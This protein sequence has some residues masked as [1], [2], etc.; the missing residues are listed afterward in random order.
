MTESYFYVQS[1]LR[2][3]AS[4]AFLQKILEFHGRVNNSKEEAIKE[5]DKLDEIK[6]QIEEAERTTE[7]ARK[8]IGNAGSDAEHAAKVAEEAQ[9]DANSIKDVNYKLPSLFCVL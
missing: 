4:I 9:Q 1:K 7:D 8:A 5:L 3:T 6:K 2:E